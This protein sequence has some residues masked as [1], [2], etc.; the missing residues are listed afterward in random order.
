MGLQ[1]SKWE[2]LGVHRSHAARMSFYRARGFQDWLER[3]TDRI[4]H[5]ILGPRRGTH[6]PARERAEAATRCATEH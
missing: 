5:E 2:R 1:R 6:G 4:R 3:R